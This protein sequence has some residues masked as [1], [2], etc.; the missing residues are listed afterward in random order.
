LP[1]WLF[2]AFLR[3]VGHFILMRWVDLPTLIDNFLKTPSIGISNTPPP[4]ETEQMKEWVFQK[5]GMM[6]NHVDERLKKPNEKISEKIQR[7]MHACLQVLLEVLHKSNYPTVEKRQHY[8]QLNLTLKDRMLRELEETA[9]PV[10]MPVV[11]LGLGSA[12]EKALEASELLGT[13]HDLLSMLDKTFQPREMPHA[14]TD[15]IDG[16]VDALLEKTACYG[17]KSDLPQRIAMTQATGFVSAIKLAFS[18]PA[19][20]R[21]LMYKAMTTSLSIC[22]ATSQPQ[23][24]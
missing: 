9:L 15:T 23:P 17:L 14:P 2:N 16:L 11:A 12:L 1:Q 5:V 18:E 22:S 24:T 6:V 7:D 10:A 20:L 21:S 13:V 4:P 3:G 8:I 19:Y